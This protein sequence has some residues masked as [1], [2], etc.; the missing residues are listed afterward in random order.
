MEGAQ[1]LGD[2]V[3][4]RDEVR[5]AFSPTPTSLQLESPATR[6]WACIQYPGHLG[7]TIQMRSSSGK[8]E[9]AHGQRASDRPQK[10]AGRSVHFVGSTPE[11]YVHESLPSICG[12]SEWSQRVRVESI[13]R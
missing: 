1:L 13:M 12:S 6:T 5:V 3:D 8:R 2:N 9:M 10:S 11:Y 7:R 4:M